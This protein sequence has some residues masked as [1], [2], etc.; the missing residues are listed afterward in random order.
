MA[1]SKDEELCLVDSATTHTILKNPKFFL[2]LQI[3][4]ANVSTI[5]GMTDIIE[6][7]ERVSILFPKGTKIQI[8]DALYSSKSPRNLLSFK[9]IRKN[10]YHVETMNENGVKYLWLTSYKTGQKQVLEKMR[11]YSSGLYGTIISPLETYAVTNQKLVDQ[12]AFSL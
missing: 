6:G 2:N 9:D 11:A 3:A 1:N 8:K 4:K 10:G 12:K 7:S 5:S